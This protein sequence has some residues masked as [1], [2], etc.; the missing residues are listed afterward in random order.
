MYLSYTEL[1]CLRQKGIDVKKYL[2]GGISS[3]VFAIA[4]YHGNDGL[5]IHDCI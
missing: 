3:K 5:C 4:P 1:S 2:G